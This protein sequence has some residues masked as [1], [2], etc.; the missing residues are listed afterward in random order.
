MNQ[1]LVVTCCDDTLPAPFE[2]VTKA[3]VCGPKLTWV[4]LMRT[5]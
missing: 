1:S 2:W 3:L 5:R 4:E